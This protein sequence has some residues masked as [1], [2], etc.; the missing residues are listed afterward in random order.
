MIALWRGVV[1][2]I[3]SLSVAVLLREAFQLRL[4]APLQAA[5]DG[6]DR[7]LAIALAGV[8]PGVAALLQPLHAAIGGGV[9]LYPH[10][11]HVFLVAVLHMAP[12]VDARYGVGGGVAGVLWC[13][14]AIAALALSLVCAAYVGAAPFVAGASNEGFFVGVF[15]AAAFCISVIANNWQADD[16]AALAR[17]EASDRRWSR[18]FARNSIVFGFLV[19]FSLAIIGLGM[20]G[21][22]MGVVDQDE[23]GYVLVGLL[24]LWVALSFVRFIFYLLFVPP[25]ETDDLVAGNGMVTNVAIMAMFLVLLPLADQISPRAGIRAVALALF[26]AALPIAAIYY[27]GRNAIGRLIGRND[28]YVGALGPP[29]LGVFIAGGAAIL[30]AN[31]IATWPP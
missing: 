23:A 30:F 14:H 21:L 29:A 4:V 19:A 27:A 10:W 3:G 15:V 9:R 22:I 13:A 8:E 31:V 6:Y 7:V 24:L 12:R 16:E 11:S 18:W 20:I 25:D 17:K 1:W 2:V 28:G 26:L 5:L